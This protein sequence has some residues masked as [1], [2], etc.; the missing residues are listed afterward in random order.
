MNVPGQ[1]DVLEQARRDVGLSIADL[2]M[3]Y[4]ALGGM[5]T[6][7][8]LEAILYNALVADVH[9]RDVLTVAI[10]ER[11]AEMGGDHPIPYSDDDPTDM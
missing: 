8:E 6:A 5:S 7:L 9:D 1:L 4:F 3:R 11:F 2:W 10:N